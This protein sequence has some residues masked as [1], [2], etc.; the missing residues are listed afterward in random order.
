AG[1]TAEGS[2]AD[3]SAGVPTGRQAIATLRRRAPEDGS[4]CF[5]RVRKPRRRRGRYHAVELAHVELQPAIGTLREHVGVARAPA[6]LR[7]AVGVARVQVL[8]GGL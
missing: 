2:C 6:N 5:T 1:R 4:R 3:Q 7:V 8:R